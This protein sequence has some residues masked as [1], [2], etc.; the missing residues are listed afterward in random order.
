K[1]A[2]LDPN[3]TLL[4]Q[5]TVHPHQPQNRRY[6]AK[7]ALKDLVAKHQV[8]VV[9]IGNGT[10]CRETE[11]LIAEIITEGTHFHN[12]PGAGPPR[13]GRRAPP[14][15]GGRR[16]PPP[17]PGPPPH[18]PGRRRRRRKPLKPRPPPR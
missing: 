17:R 12:N 9:A 16:A 14:P 15:R 11:E 7:Q 5:T 18:P 4:E 3:G 1:V 13:A 8:G 10:A 6:E 2:V